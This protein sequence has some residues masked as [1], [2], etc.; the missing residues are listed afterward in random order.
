M[1][2]VVQR[3][4]RASVAVGGEVVG[5]TGPGLLVLVGFRVGDDRAALDWMASRL[6]GLRIFA[7][8]GGRMNLSVAE[9]GGELL[10]VSQFTLYGDAAKGR[11]PSFVRAA[12]PRLA[13][14]LYDEF[15]GKLDALLPGRVQRG[16]FGAAMQVALLNDGPVTL[17]IDRDA[18]GSTRRS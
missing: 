2:I 14:P 12:P 3:V 15:L 4:A 13:E 5:K 11:R 1:R 8:D 17:V 10:V 16:R 18:A 9:T 7:D 6:V